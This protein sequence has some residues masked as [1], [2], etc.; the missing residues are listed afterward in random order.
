MSG[1]VVLMKNYLKQHDETID[2]DMDIVCVKLDKELFSTIRY[3]MMYLH[4]CPP[5]G[6]HVVPSNR[7]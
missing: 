6:F 5:K 2:T 1:V 4:V 7:Y 3:I